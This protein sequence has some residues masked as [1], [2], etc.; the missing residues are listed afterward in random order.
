MLFVPGNRSLSYFASDC[1]SNLSICNH[2]EISFASRPY[3]R[4]KTQ[5]C[6]TAQLEKMKQIKR[7]TRC[8]RQHE[9][10]PEASHWWKWLCGEGPGVGKSIASGSRSPSPLLSTECCAG[11]CWAPS[12]AWTG[13]HWSPAQ[14]C[15]VALT[16][17]GA[18]G[19]WRRGGWGG[20]EKRQDKQQWAHTEIREIPFKHRGENPSFAVRAISPGKGLP[21]EMVECPSLGTVAT[22]TAGAG[23]PAVPGHEPRSLPAPVL[24]C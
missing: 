2:Y 9:I 5:L 3:V 10:P 1:K 20:S 19:A 13:T 12:T 16:Y 21:R 17:R 11:C 15:E 6:D 23:Q 14:R 24:Q 8:H 22:R 4:R 7:I 18:E